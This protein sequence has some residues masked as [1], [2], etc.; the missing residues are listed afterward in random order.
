MH[1][2][3]IVGAMPLAMHPNHFIRFHDRFSAGTLLAQKLMRYANRSDVIVLSLPRGG[4]LVAGAVA[5]LLAAPLDILTVRK[6]GAPRQKELAIG[7]IAAGGIS[8]LNE[9]TIAF[10]HVSKD[11]IAETITRERHEL[12]RREALYRGNRPKQVL[13]GKIVILADDGLATGSTM[14]AAVASAHCGYPARVI[15]AVP[16]GAPDTC[17]ELRREVDEIVCLH[18]PDPFEAV[19]CWYEDFREVTD[20]EVRAALR[21][22]TADP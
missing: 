10:L 11:E 3:E 15:I 5:A 12:E 8:Y 1:G 17:E 13:A 2:R 18:T 14:R 21:S 9:E 22:F 19:G 16:V 20:D 7:A 4:V 6:L